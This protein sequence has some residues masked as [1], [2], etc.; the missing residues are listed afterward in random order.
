[1]RRLSWF[2]LPLLGVLAAVSA[3]A[4]TRDPDEQ[5]CLFAAP[6]RNTMVACNRYLGKVND[7]IKQG[8]SGK[9]RPKKGTKDG[10]LSGLYT[11]R[12]GA[13]RVIARRHAANEEDLKAR[14]LHRK[15][16]DDFDMAVRLDPT[17]PHAY[18]NR[19]GSWAELIEHD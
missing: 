6:D 7:A 4:Q 11:F 13:Y 14:E 19:G 17:Q 8:G 3:A 1:M 15:A 5:A 10:L 18:L 16:I 9:A 12:G 2:M